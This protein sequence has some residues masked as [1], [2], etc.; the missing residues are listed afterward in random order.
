MEAE[1][2]IARMAAFVVVPR[3][4]RMPFV[5]RGPPRRARILCRVPATSFLCYQR[6][7][8]VTAHNN[9]LSLIAHGV[10][11]LLVPQIILDEAQVAAL[12]GQVVDAS[13]PQLV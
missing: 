13:V 7:D 1:Q 4:S 12:V 10:L 2:D 9:L 5:N 6:A 3:R 11:D 8:D